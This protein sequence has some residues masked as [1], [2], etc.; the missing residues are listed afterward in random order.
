MTIARPAP[1][2][3]DYYRSTEG[4]NAR[5]A[6]SRNLIQAEALAQL[7]YGESGEALRNLNDD[8]QDNVCFLLSDLIGEC[9]LFR[10]KA[11]QEAA[12]QPTAH[13][14]A[15]ELHKAHRIIAIALNALEGDARQHFIGDVCSAGLE[16]EGVTRANER[17]ELLAKMGIDVREVRI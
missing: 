7:L 9:R 1:I 12:S 10:H 14:M 11:K 4:E 6:F 2:L 15:Q 5:D 8:V 17:A 16:G 3:G 13:E